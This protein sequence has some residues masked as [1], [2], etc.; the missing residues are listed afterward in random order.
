[1]QRCFSE[2]SYYH[3]NL[4]FRPS[5]THVHM[6]AMYTTWV[7]ILYKSGLPLVRIN[8]NEKFSFAPWGHA[9]ETHAATHRHTH[10]V[11]TLLSPSEF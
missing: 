5:E 8:A 10:A 6:D 4:K 9:A 7:C 11:G 2:W 1:L 3:R